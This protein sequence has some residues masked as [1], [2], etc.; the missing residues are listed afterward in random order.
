MLL[1]TLQSFS[2]HSGSM[3]ENAN[4]YG[5]VQDLIR[6]VKCPF[7]ARHQPWIMPTT[8]SSCMVELLMKCLLSIDQENE[9]KLPT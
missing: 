4:L 6:Q 2:E 5:S 7:L 9:R 8:M 3:K 1:S